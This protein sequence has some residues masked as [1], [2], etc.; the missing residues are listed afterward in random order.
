MT[1][2]LAKS[3]HQMPVNPRRAG[4]PLLRLTPCTRCFHATNLPRRAPNSSEAFARRLGA[5]R[6]RE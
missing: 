1:T 2:N 5:C 6:R 4:L 3:L